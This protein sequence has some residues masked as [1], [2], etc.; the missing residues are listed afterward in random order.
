MKRIFT[1]MLFGLT[2]LAWP[3]WAQEIDESFIFTDAS[4]IEIENGSTVTRNV[5][6]EN[7]GIEQINA[8]VYVKNVVGSNDYLKMHYSIERL[9]NGA[10]QIC[11]PMNCNSQAQVGDYVTDYGHLMG[12]TQDIMSEWMPVDDGEC[13]VKLTLEL[14]TRQ[15]MFPPSYVHKA[16][17][18]SITVRFVKGGAPEPVKGDVNGDGEVNISDINAVILAILT[19]DL[20]NEAAD[21]NGD[22]EVNISDI[23]AV[24]AIILNPSD[25]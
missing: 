15:G 18:P 4:G 17:G 16:W 14:F 12:N 6:V 13:I 20:S 2:M 21:V 1:F 25:E 9:D 19:N 11:F 5:V 10:Y 7:E 24:I 22:G 8:E 23:N 3:A